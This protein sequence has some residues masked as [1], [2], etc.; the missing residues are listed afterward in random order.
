MTSGRTAAGPPAPR[1][2]FGDFLLVWFGALVVAV[3]VQTVAL[4]ILGVTDTTHIPRPDEITSTVVTLYAQG[5]AMALGVAL[6]AWWRGG[7][8]T[9]RT[10]F[11]FVLRFRDAG[12]M[13]IGVLISLG[14]VVLITPVTRLHDKAVEQHVVTLYREA[15]GGQRAAF[16]IAVG[17]VAPIAEELLFRGLLLRSLQRRLP[18]VAAVIVAALVFAA[19]HLV[20]PSAYVA[21]FPL[22][23]LSLVSGY[24]AVR[25]F[26]L[27]RSIFLHIGFNL[28][29]VVVLLLGKSTT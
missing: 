11:G 22:M 5:A 7:G 25:T 3:V 14:T 6:V 18:T 24:A 17:I 13:L 20:D 9:L 2:G 8:Q 12:W 23:V 10:A 1:W 21:L 26:E 27:S 4:S 29:T 28:L 19:A 16:A 15:S